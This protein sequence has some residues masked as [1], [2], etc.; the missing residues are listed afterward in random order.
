MTT[1]RFFAIGSWTE[2][3]FHFQK[4]RPFVVSYEPARIKASAYRLPIGFPVL[5]AQNEGTQE[6]TAA[7]EILGQLI[8]LKFDPTLLALMDTLH[9]VNPIEPAKGLHQRVRTQVTKNSGETEVV[10]T[11]F[12][13]PAKLTAKAARIAGGVWQE[14]LAQ[15]PPIVEQ[16]TEKQRTYVKKL[17]SAKGRDIV[18]INDLSL[19]RELMKLDLIVDKGRR[20][21]LSLLGKEV[22]NHLV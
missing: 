21:A 14:S 5:V 13:N 19:Y 16:L 1:M 9:G 3:M 2:G 4:L 7:D 8:E 18:P 15:N 6:P 22:Y 17:G 20:L 12:Y 11:Y 10:E